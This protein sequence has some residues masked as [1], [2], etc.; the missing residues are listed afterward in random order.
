MC[1]DLLHVMF[2]MLSKNMMNVL[3]LCNNMVKNGEI[4]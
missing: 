3:M 1:Q 2:M 4:F